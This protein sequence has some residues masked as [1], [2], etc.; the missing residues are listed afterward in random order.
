MD[1]GG[2]FVQPFR[3][4]LFCHFGNRLAGIDVVMGV[5]GRWSWSEVTLLSSPQR[6]GALIV[7][8]PAMQ[9]VAAAPR[10]IFRIM[11]T[12]PHDWLQ[13]P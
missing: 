7:V 12:P 1:D 11:T 6:H 8:H 4:F 9:A 13:A 5:D 2:T 3:F 10:S